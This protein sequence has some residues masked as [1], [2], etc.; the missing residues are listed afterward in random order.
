MFPRAIPAVFVAGFIASASVAGAQQTEPTP[1]TV[2]VT[3][4]MNADGS[5]TVYEFDSL[6]HK[7]KATTA[8][9]NGKP[10]GTIRYTLDDAGRFMRGEVYGPDDQFRF[11]TLYRYDEAGRLSQETQLSKDDAVQHKLIYAYDKNGR[12]TGYAVYDASGKLVSQKGPSPT[13]TP[14]NK[15]R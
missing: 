14:T 12:Q 7:A 15:R 3:V 13:A 9:K 2:R 6:R 5:R 4:S 11:K 1:E 10:L 8:D